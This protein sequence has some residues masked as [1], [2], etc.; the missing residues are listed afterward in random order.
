[1]ILLNKDNKYKK[2]LFKDKG[3]AK[4]TRDWI[5]IKVLDLSLA[6]PI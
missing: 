4:E 3:V 1:V 2:G 6:K 5:N